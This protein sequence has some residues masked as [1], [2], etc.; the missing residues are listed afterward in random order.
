MLPQ[1]FSM[2]FCVG[3]TDPY[4][5]GGT[6]AIALALV[7]DRAWEAGTQEGGV[8]ANGRQ[9]NKGASLP[10]FLHEMPMRPKYLARN[11][12]IHKHEGKTWMNLKSCGLS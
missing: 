10:H 1:L 3:E 12:E 6:N 4:A 2:A 7:S 8:E 11:S 5:H 9:G